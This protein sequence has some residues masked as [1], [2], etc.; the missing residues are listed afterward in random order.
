MNEKIF[1]FFNDL[2]GEN[3]LLDK[4]MVFGGVNLIYLM[5][6]VAGVIVAY[7]LY[8]REYYRA[9]LFVA[10]LALTFVLLQLLAFTH[11]NERPYIEYDVTQLVEREPSRSFPSNHAGAA[12]AIAL[13]SIFITKPKAALALLLAAV[14]V[15]TSRIFTGLHHPIDIGGS[16]LAAAVALAGIYAGDRF[17]THR[18][19]KSDTKTEPYQD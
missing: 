4:L 18:Q 13:G 19:A 2:A 6:L 3:A 8:K 16:I 1:F 11:V 5:F 10:V 17:L 14:A 9:G 7:A 15:G 12:F